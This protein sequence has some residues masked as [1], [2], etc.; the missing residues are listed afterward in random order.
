M[1]LSYNRCPRPNYVYLF[2]TLSA[3]FNNNA[4]YSGFILNLLIRP[5]GS[6]ILCERY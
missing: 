3:S 6:Y 2:Q 5:H 4:H 1:Q